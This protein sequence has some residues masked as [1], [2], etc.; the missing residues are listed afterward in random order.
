MVVSHGRKLIGVISATDVRML[1]AHMERADRLL[2]SAGAFVHT[3]QK[4]N[5][6]VRTPILLSL[7][8]L[9]LSLSLSPP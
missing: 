2:S 3:V 6:L 9:A 7:S 4:Q 5:P 8:L 1:G